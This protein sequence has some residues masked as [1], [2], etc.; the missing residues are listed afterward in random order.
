MELHTLEPNQADQNLPCPGTPWPVPA[1]TTGMHK[2]VR[3]GGTLQWQEQAVQEGQ[4]LSVLPAQALCSLTG[5]WEGNT[6]NVLPLSPHQV[7]WETTG[8][9]STVL[10]RALF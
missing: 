7:T 10:W 4:E 3:R 2:G 5:T 9:S 8:R 6:W 1:G